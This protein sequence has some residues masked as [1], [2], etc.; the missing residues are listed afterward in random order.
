MALWS[1]TSQERTRLMLWRTGNSTFRVVQYDEPA[2]MLSNSDYI[3]FDQKYESV[4]QQLKGQ[5]DFLAVTVTDGVRHLVWDNYLE[6]RIRRSLEIDA[7]PA[8]SGHGLDMY[9]FGEESVYVSEA[10]KE[11]FEKVSPQKLRFSLGL[12]E[13]AA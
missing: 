4:L 1:L 9:R 13:F 3:L 10:L 12:S 7:I 5:I 8:Y 2:D 11:A 6:V